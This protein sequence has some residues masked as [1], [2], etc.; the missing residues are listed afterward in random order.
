MWDKLKKNFIKYREIVLYALF[1][2]L[3]TIINIALYYIATR[4]F[5]IN[6]L[7]ATIISWFFSVFFAYITNRKWVFSSK[8]KTLM[9]IIGEMMRFFGCRIASGIIDWGG[10]WFFIEIVGMN[11][12]IMKILMNILVVVFNFMASK[13]VIFKKV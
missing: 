8:E 5:S 11:D 12:M 6:V 9:G 7:S 2:G 13:I 1:G 3:T 10:M 4:W